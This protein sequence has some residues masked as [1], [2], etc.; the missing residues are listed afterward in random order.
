VAL[1]NTGG[2]YGMEPRMAARAAKSLRAKLAIPHH[3]GTSEGMAPDASVFLSELK[4]LKIASRE[5][6]VGE[7]LV[8]SGHAL[9]AN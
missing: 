4:K 1:L 3:F 5:M 9:R 6:K 8:F 7:T 2:H